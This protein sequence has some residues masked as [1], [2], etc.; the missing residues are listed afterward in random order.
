MVERIAIPY[1]KHR[2][3]KLAVVLFD[4]DNHRYVFCVTH[5][6]MVDVRVDKFRVK[7]EVEGILNVAYAACMKLIDDLH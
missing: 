6:E 5:K 1:G 2:L 3:C 7:K 4:G